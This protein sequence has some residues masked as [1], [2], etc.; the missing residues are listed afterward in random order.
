MLLVMDCVTSDAVC[1]SNPKKWPLLVN[2]SLVVQRLE[3]PFQNTEGHGFESHL[4]LGFFLCPLIVDSLHL[5]LFA[6]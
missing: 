5:P 2:D 3:H 4:G 1:K 6:L